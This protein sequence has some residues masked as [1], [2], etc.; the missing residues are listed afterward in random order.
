MLRQFASSS[1]ERLLK[2]P[3]ELKRHGSS[4]PKRIPGGEDAKSGNTS[5]GWTPEIT[6][7]GDGRNFSIQNRWI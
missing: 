4:K 5:G 1:I 6:M 7:I 3:R 2:L